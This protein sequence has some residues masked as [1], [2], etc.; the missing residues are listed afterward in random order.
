MADKLDQYGDVAHHT[1]VKRVG[2]LKQAVCTCGW[3]GRRFDVG[4]NAQH[5]GDEHTRQMSGSR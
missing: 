4:K 2:L 5:D 1:E 3:H